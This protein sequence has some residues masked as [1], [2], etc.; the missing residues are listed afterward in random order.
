MLIQRLR[1]G[2]HLVSLVRENKYRSVVKLLLVIY[3]LQTRPVLE[4]IL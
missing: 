1:K 2:C 4:T 3:Y